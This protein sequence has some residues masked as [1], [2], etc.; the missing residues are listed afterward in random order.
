VVIEVEEL[1][2]SAIEVVIAEF[3][4]GTAREEQR[5]EEYPKDDGDEESPS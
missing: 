3:R 2:R 1:W 5:A 4:T